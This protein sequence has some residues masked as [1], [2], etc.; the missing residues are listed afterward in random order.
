MKIVYSLL[1]SISLFLSSF[2]INFSNLSEIFFDNIEIKKVYYDN[3]LV[4]VG[5]KEPIYW[6]QNK[7]FLGNGFPTTMTRTG[8]TSGTI[9]VPEIDAGGDEDQNAES[10]AT[11]AK[12]STNGYRYMTFSIELG[13]V[14]GPNT[15][16]KNPG[17]FWVYAED[18]TQLFYQNGSGTYTV[19]I[20]SVDTIYI[21][22]SAGAWAYNNSIA[23]VKT[24]YFHD[25]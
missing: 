18:G 25:E 17:Q 12:V 20:S 2:S 11:S 9:T 15:N 13:T 5:I 10:Y 3:E 4:W 1:L 16:Y 6:I 23:R 8:S 21:Q 7:Q 22:M 19:D 14:Y 24:L